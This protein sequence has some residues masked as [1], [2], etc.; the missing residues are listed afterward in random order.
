MLAKR[1]AA[2]TIQRAC[3]EGEPVQ[4]VEIKIAAKAG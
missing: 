4:R 2:N 3:I 1:K